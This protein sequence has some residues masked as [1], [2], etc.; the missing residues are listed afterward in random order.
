MVIL[1]FKKTDTFDKK[2]RI[3]D[4]DCKIT[5]KFNGL[6]NLQFRLFDDE[7][8]HCE[9]RFECL[10][11]RYVVKAI[12]N[13]NVSC[14]LDLNDFHTT[15]FTGKSKYNRLTL[16]EML[17]KI[18]NWE[19]LN[20]QSKTFRRTLNI[21]DCSAFKVLFDIEKIFD[22]AFVFDCIN[23]TIKVVDEPNKTNLIVSKTVNLESIDMTT[24]TYEHYTRLYAYGKDGLSF[25]EINDGKDYV[26]DFTYNSNVISA[27]FRDD[28]FTNKD[29]LKAKALEL[30]KIHCKP[31]TE[32][33]V[34]VKDLGASVLYSDNH[35]Y[36]KY[37]KALS[38][39][40]EF[41]LENHLIK[42][43]GIKDRLEKYRVIELVS[44]TGDPQ[45][46]EVT[47]VN[48]GRSLN[49]MLAG[50]DEKITTDVLRKVNDEFSTRFDENRKEL[51]KHFE[52]LRSSGHKI[53]EN[54][55]I[56]F[57]DKLPKEQAKNV[58][59]IGV[60]GIM[61][62]S[63]GFLG[64]YETA[65]T[66]D[67]R[68]NL[69]K[70]MVGELDGHYIRANTVD[71]DKLTME[72]R[73]KLKNGLVT[74][75]E[76][77]KF[78]LD[79][80]GFN[81]Y[82]EQKVNEKGEVLKKYASDFFTEKE[83]VI[84]HE[85]NSS[86]DNKAKSLKSEFDSKADSLKSEINSSI[87]SKTNNLKSEINST[88][89]VIESKFD[90]RLDDRVDLINSNVD[91]KIAE[92]NKGIDGKIKS[93]DDKLRNEIGSSIGNIY[94]DLNKKN[95]E[96][97]QKQDKDI[98]SLKSDVDKK[99]DDNSRSLNSKMDNMNRNFE[100]GGKYLY[101]LYTTSNNRLDN[102]LKNVDGKIAGAVNEMNG[103]AEKLAYDINKSAGNLRSEFNK[104]IDDKT[105]V[106]RSDINSNT[107]K[108]N[109]NIKKIELIER[110]TKKFR[111]FSSTIDEFKSKIG[112]I[113]KN[114]FEITTEGKNLC[115]ETGET[116]H[117]N[118][119]D[120]NTTETLKANKE[121]YILAEAS[122]VKNDK[123]WTKIYNANLKQLD[124]FDANYR[125]QSGKILVNGLNVW[126]VSYDHD[127]THVNIWPCGSDTTIKKVRIYEA[128]KSEDKKNLYV[129]HNISSPG[130]NGT[131]KKIEFRV[132]EKL[133]Y[134]EIY[135]IEFNSGVQFKYHIVNNYSN[136]F[137]ATFISNGASSMTGENG[138]YFEEKNTN[139]TFYVTMLVTMSEDAELK[140]YGDVKIYK[141][142]IKNTTKSGFD[143]IN[144]ISSQIRQTKSEI[145]LTV[146]KNDIINSINVSPEG[147]K[148]KGGAIVDVLEG[149]E[150]IGG[151]IKGNYRMEIGDTG[152]MYPCYDDDV[153]GLVM[154][155]PHKGGNSGIVC[156]FNGNPK[157]Q[158]KGKD[159]YYPLGLYIY[160]CENDWNRVDD[161]DSYILHVD[162][163]VNA[164]GVGGIR[165]DDAPPKYKGNNLW[166]IGACEKEHSNV[167]LSFGGGDNDIYYDW[168]GT[169]YSLYKAI[170]SS[171]S[172]RRL[173]TNIKKSLS[174]GLDIVNRLKFYSF[175]WRKDKIKDKNKAG[176]KIGM[177][178]QDVEK[179]DKDL[180]YT[181][182][183][184]KFVDTYRMLN[185][186][187]KAIQ[188][189]SGK[190]A[191]LESECKGA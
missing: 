3:L 131:L 47:V 166:G 27:V 39:H 77:S 57:V 84:K 167:K 182:G 124:I 104:N 24:D 120:F 147:T 12:E 132:S 157:T 82:I 128:S 156:Q 185:V 117:G 121:Y 54:G 8:L 106:L 18:T 172:D 158:A 13:Y 15:F 162:G 59:K 125:L 43:R 64:P 19:I 58:L 21:E 140:L 141:S 122:G 56:Y 123:Q 129:S 137:D 32:F 153:S 26:E 61:G 179:I 73:E 183:G 180:I 49:K 5:Y 105:G 44:F 35:Y 142:N 138:Y 145:D 20:G 102:E 174:S 2:E 50:I 76:F 70:A 9:D 169:L 133:E 98:Q 164:K 86:I 25:S 111:E 136:F 144:E 40:D 42:G 151:I 115:A 33:K 28:R 69:N 160:R 16:I 60:G 107:S 187:L 173:K 101:D 135:A 78:K 75:E 66:N 118:D 178:A 87:D 181:E 94:D 100:E 130:S 46:N 103:K 134:G 112:E 113:E 189:L 7:V 90:Y 190:V 170:I 175:D 17:K 155:I 71:F 11:N 83:E 68:I 177:I 6:V 127:V 38:L 52:D 1:K 154:K 161:N 97:G 23:K 93:S 62:S 168:N 67:G 186:A 119:L 63:N 80:D 4:R 41:Y 91:S 165:F 146:K 88:I 31:I 152:Y 116:K 96:L 188:E 163:F 79:K 114:K 72:A 171:S 55:T 159:R 48:R 34:K 148:I 109:N 99:I 139:G 92:V 191:R 95:Y 126:K 22:V 149:K 176:F 89:D 150:I 29:N 85:F 53:E 184:S 51:E 108:I 36:A 110:D 14:E 45:A 81:Q 65:I 10:G 37:L 74:T 143:V 30:L